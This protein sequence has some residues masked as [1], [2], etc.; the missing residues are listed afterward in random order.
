MRRHTDWDD[1]VFGADS[2]ELGREV[3]AMAIED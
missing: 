2:I 3:A 1:I